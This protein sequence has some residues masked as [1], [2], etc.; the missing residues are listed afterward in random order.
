MVSIR[1]S[2]TDRRHLAGN[3]LLPGNS[4][5]AHAL[6]SLG[7]LGQYVLAGQI[8]GTDDASADSETAT[9]AADPAPGSTYHDG[10]GAI[11]S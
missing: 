10:Q 6:T 3:S 4:V 7:D 2:V 11:R 8:A 5:T 1:G 9:I